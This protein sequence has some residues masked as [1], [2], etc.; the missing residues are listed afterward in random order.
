VQAIGLSG[1][2]AWWR[3]HR[4]TTAAD[5]VALADLL[6]RLQAW[7]AQHDRDRAGQPG[8]F[9]KMVWDGIFGDED[10]Q[11]TDAIAEVEAALAAVR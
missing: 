8:P 7:K 1:D 9:L 10:E 5:P 2:L 6:E 4:G 3:D 11:V